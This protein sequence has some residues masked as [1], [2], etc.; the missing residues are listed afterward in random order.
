MAHVL[1]CA[2]AIA[3]TNEKDCSFSAPTVTPFSPKCEANAS[4]GDA[5]PAGSFD[6]GSVHLSMK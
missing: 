2:R 4:C 6:I 3:R 5:T 1:A